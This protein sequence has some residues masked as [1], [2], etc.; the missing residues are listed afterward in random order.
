MPVWASAG[1][2]KA[3]PS[4]QAKAPAITV[5]RVMLF[6]IHSS[7]GSARHIGGTAN[8]PGADEFSSSTANGPLFKDNAARMGSFPAAYDD[9]L[10]FSFHCD[11]S[12]TTAM[13]ARMVSSPAS[14]G[15]GAEACAPVLARA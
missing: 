12:H 14:T 6:L 1:A 8:F 4:T 9:L 3:K 10:I 13:S 2:A 7:F 15:T 11:N 5:G